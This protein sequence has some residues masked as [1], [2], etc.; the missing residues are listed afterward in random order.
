MFYFD[1]LEI[2]ELGTSTSFELVETETV[3]FAQQWDPQPFHV[4]KATATGSIYGGLTASGCHLVCIANLLWKQF[5]R[6]AILGLLAQKF[7]YPTPA[8]PGDHL[9]L[10]AEIVDKRASTSKPDRGILTLRA[11][12]TTQDGTAVLLEESTVMIGKKRQVD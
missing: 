3:A 7:Q 10:I 2:G 9:T 11:T 8:R 12:L 4:D 1:D 5:G 6:W